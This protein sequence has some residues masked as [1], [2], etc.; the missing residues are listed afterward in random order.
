MPPQIC[1]HAGPILSRYNALICDVWGVVHDGGRAYPAAGEALARFRSAGGTVVLLSNSPMPSHAVV[2]VLDNKGVRR[3]IADAIVTS[4]D[5]TQAH[6][7][8]HRISHVHHIGPDRDL[9]LF[10]GT[11]LT[12][13][14]LASAK[15][16]VCTGLVDDIRHTAE[17]YRPLLAKAHNAGLPLVCANPDMAV[18]VGGQRLPCAGVVAALY[19]SLGGEVIWAGK[20][21]AVA[22]ARA[23]ETIAGLRGGPPPKRSI[24]AIGDALGT[25]IAGAAQAGLDALFIAQGI[26]HD[27]LMIDGRLLPERLEGFIASAPP[28]LARTIIATMPALV[29]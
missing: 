7:A 25:D 15:A 1:A 3:D 23:I 20:P 28:A 10:D 9:V 4:G 17:T 2:G 13:T 6:L 14:D 21:H 29:W 27:E 5:I 12:L 18:D 19:E 24:L 16:I 11:G 26:H 22:F 8:E